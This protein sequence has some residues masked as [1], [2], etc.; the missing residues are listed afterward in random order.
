MK[1]TLR[2]AAFASLG[3]ALLF[4][5]TTISADDKDKPKKEAPIVLPL[6]GESKTI[7]LFNGKLNEMTTRT[8]SGSSLVKG[9][10]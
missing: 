5:G 2:L 10:T 1:R 3:L 8:A 9:S 7:K 4:C 6:T